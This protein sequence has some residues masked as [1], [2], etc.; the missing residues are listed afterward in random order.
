MIEGI[1]RPASRASAI[2]AVVRPADRADVEAAAVGEHQRPTV[3][4]HRILPALITLYHEGHAVD[5]VGLF[6]PAAGHLARTR[7]LDRPLLD[8]AVRLL[9]VYVDPAVRVHPLHFG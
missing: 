3:G 1:A 4:E 8:G 5:R 2:G 9:D 7:G 6:Q